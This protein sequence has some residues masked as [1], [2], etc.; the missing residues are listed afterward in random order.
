MKKSLFALAIIISFMF[1]TF[2]PPKDRNIGRWK[3]KYGN[4]LM[5]TID[6]KAD[7]T[8][9][10]SFEK[11]DFKVGGIYITRDDILYIADTSC[12][13]NYWGKYRQTFYTDDSVLNNVLEDS[14]SRRKASADKS[15]FI[16]MN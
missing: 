16:R 4:D 10:T 8:F 12:G 14:C 2:V 11:S 6:F 3:A 1:F 9:E 13:E 7:G 15:V 5:G